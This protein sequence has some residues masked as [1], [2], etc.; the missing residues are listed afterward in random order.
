M[1]HFPY[2]DVCMV[3]IVALSLQSIVAVRANKT[4]YYA[5]YTAWG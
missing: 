3:L 4:I 1:Y 5:V 2:F